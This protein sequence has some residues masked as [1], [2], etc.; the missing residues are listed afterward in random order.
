MTERKQYPMATG[1]L[2]Y[3]PDALM[4]VAYVSWVGNQQHNLGEP[5]HW[6]RDKSKD[7]PDALLRHLKDRGKR[8]TDG[9]R[10]SGKVA[11]RALAIL[12]EEIES[13][14]ER[15]QREYMGPMDRD[16]VP[17]LGPVW[18]PSKEGREI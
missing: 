15:S 8:D 1:L 14:R 11:W 10:H 13:E 7:H 3:F 6:A 12:Q 17:P 4:E 18:S 16:D 2:D 9:V 5:L